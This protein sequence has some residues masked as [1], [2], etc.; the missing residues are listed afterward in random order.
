MGRHTL[1]GPVLAFRL[2]G[3]LEAWAATCFPLSARVTGPE[4][5]GS[6]LLRVKL[7]LILILMKALTI[8]FSIVFSVALSGCDQVRNVA[9]DWLRPPSVG[10]VAARVSE[11]AT[12]GKVNQAIALGED[13]LTKNSDPSGDLHRTLADLYLSQGDTVSSIRHLEKSQ[14]TVGSAAVVSQ[15]VP[16]T[17]QVRAVPPEQVERPP[18]V[19]ATVDGASARVR[20][21]GSLEV[22]AGSAVAGT[23]R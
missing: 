20:A 7:L 9:A 6:K 11:L 18:A 10:E 1:F 21:D 16:P 19:S 8:F 17:P 5:G 13:F 22:R 14:G 2:A 15:G 4:S 3:R 23:G 12:S